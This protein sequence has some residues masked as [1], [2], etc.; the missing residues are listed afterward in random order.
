M[1]QAPSSGL[2][3]TIFDGPHHRWFICQSPLTSPC[4]LTTP[5][6]VFHVPTIGFGRGPTFPHHHAK[7]GNKELKSETREMTGELEAVEVSREVFCS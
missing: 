6:N 5:V 2:N 3:R 7:R 4:Q 1:V